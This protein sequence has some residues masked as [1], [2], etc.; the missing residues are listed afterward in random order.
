[1]LRDAVRGTNAA[2]SAQGFAEWLRELGGA[3]NS[4]CS[5]NVFEIAEGETV[6]DEIARRRK[7]LKAVVA[8]L[9]E[10]ES[11]KG[12]TRAEFV[13][14]KFNELEQSLKR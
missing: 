2:A 11:L 7:V 4:Y 3:P 14:G 1:M 13:R 10:S 8:I 9:S 5:G 6:E 12:D